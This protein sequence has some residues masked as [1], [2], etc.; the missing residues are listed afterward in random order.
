MNLTSFFRKDSAIE[1]HSLVDLNW[2]EDPSVMDLSSIRNPNNIKPEVEMEW[3]LGGPTIDLDE[4]AG[5]VERNLPEDAVGDASAVI[6]F[7]RDMM[8]RGCS[9]RQVAASLKSKYPP[10]LLAKASKGL[11]GLFAMD[12]LVGRILVDARGY[13]SCK[14][15]M[16]SASASPYKHFIK[17][18]YG[19]ECGDPHDL[20]VNDAMVIG[21]VPE[22]TGNAM[23]DFMA[24]EMVGMEF[25]T[26]KEMDDYKRE[27]DVRPGTKM[28]V[29]PEAKKS[30]KPGSKSVQKATKEDIEKA[31]P[32]S[33]FIVDGTAMDRKDALKELALGARVGIVHPKDMSKTA[34]HCRSTML[35]RMAA[36]DLDK[37][38]MD[39]TLTEMMNT[40]PLPEGV[41]KGL[42]ATKASNMAKV[43]AAFRWLDK[44]ADKAD[45]AKYA[46]KVDA[47]EY[48]LKRA[49]NEIDIVD[50]VP[51]D[52]AVNEMP[53]E[54]DVEIF[55]AP[56]SSLDF[57]VEQFKEPE[58]E[59]VGEE[60]DLDEEVVPDGLVDVELLSR[61]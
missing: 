53:G 8:N 27:H 36:G 26:T 40:T 56:D 25:D 32:D 42:R 51:S 20:P 7:A 30:E 19:C 45:D 57:D 33:M 37:S 9:G 16:K 61:P 48:K 43:R 49:D 60:V 13:K 5:V 17:C 2:L 34:S 29:K 22:T 28:T 44:Q 39:S 59:G 21:P 15:A 4:P 50:A 46:G 3:G 55:D 23:D 10:V 58:F 14:D 24:R 52:I 18:V 31:H 6:L 54:L 41:V 38:L 35:P 47:S 11:R 1:D 12:G